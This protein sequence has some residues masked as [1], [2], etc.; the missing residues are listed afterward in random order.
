M[1]V[2]MCVCVCVYVLV[3]VRLCVCMFVHAAN[4]HVCV[5]VDVFAC[6]IFRRSR[7]KY[8]KEHVIETIS[9]PSIRMLKT[10]NLGP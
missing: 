3:C 1:C 6:V 5:C 10:S 8:F 7:E 9:K 2:F 4:M